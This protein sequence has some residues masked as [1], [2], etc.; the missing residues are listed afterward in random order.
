MQGSLQKMRNLPMK[1]GGEKSRFSEP[2][3][4]EEEKDFLE[5]PQDNMPFLGWSDQQ[6]PFDVIYNFLNENLHGLGSLYGLRLD[7]LL[8]S[9]ILM[10]MQNHCCCFSHSLKSSLFGSSLTDG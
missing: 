6:Q 3:P 4:E 1:Q 9:P 5:E 7:L 2:A 8:L 10:Q